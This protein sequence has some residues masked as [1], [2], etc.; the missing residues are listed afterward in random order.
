MGF[1]KSSI[2]LILTEKGASFTELSKLSLIAY[3]YAFKIFF[4]PIQ[5]SVANLVGLCNI[6]RFIFQA[7]GKERHTSYQP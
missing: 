6:N 4:A 7:L 3:P 2:T 1:F 5:D